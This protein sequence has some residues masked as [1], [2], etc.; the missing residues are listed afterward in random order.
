[1]HINGS[2]A[3]L[4]NRC[5]SVILARFALKSF[6]N[7]D[8]AVWMHDKAKRKAIYLLGL[9]SLILLPLTPWGYPSKCFCCTM[10]EDKLLFVHTCMYGFFLHRYF[11]GITWQNK[12]GFVREDTQF[13]HSG[14]RKILLTT[15]IWHLCIPIICSSIFHFLGTSL[16]ILSKEYFKY[17]KMM[18]A[19]CG[20]HHT[21]QR[22]EP[23]VPWNFSFPTWR[24]CRPGNWML[25]TAGDEGFFSS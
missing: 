22:W 15:K 11:L 9:R 7:W 24:V 25:L 1:M 21:Y 2:Q 6:S 23:I 18:C 19:L 17:Q 10:F 12:R 8:C 13:R 14:K 3:S 5:L 4:W 20:C 16:M